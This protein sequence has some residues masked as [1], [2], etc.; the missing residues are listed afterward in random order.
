MQTD[1]QQQISFKVAAPVIPASVAIFLRER[2][3]THCRADA[4]FPGGWH[5]WKL[6]PS[7]DLILSGS[8]YCEGIEVTPLVAAAFRW[9]PCHGLAC[10]PE[11]AVEL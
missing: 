6:H 3:G 9:S 10:I 5:G 1:L 4:D 7:G 11:D 2:G 8:F